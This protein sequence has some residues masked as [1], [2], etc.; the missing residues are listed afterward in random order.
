MN[1]IY[2]ENLLVLC[3]RQQQTG[4]LPNMVSAQRHVA[5]EASIFE[6]LIGEIEI[7]PYRRQPLRAR[8]SPEREG[9][10][11]IRRRVVIIDDLVGGE[12]R[13]PSGEMKLRV[14]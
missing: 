1:G 5:A 7:S 9:V 4:I 12:Q 10:S 6:V 14:E 2:G 13:D 3:V 8:K 11:G